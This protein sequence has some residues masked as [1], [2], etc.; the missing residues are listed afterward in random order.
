MALTA[1]PYAA[2]GPGYVL[3]DWFALANA[4]FDGW[5]MAAGADQW[6]ARPGAGAVYAL[7]FGLVG[8]RPGLVFALQSVL[9]VASAWAI[10]RLLARFVA[11]AA[12]WTV[13]AAWIV[14]P[15][16][17]SLL[18]WP[19]AMNI[20]ASLLLLLVGLDLVW[21]DRLGYAALALAASV[22]AYEATAGAALLGVVAVPALAQRGWRRPALV[23]GGAVVAAV[24]WTIAFFHPAKR[25]LDVTADLSLLLPAHAGWGVFPDGAVAMA[26]GLVFSLGLTW[27]AVESLRRRRWSGDA[28]LTF[29]GIAVIVVGTLPF[30]AYFYAPLGAGDRVNVV[31]GVGTAMAWV[32]LGRWAWAHAPGPALA[33]SG[34]V[35]AAMLVAA[36]S[37]ATAWADAVDDGERILAGLPDVSPGGSVDVAPPPVRRNVAAFLDPSNIRSAVQLEARTREV[38]VRFRP[39]R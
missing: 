10:M 3:D 21:R 4:H 19:S 24:A 35:V 20:T 37:A 28:A 22:L 34:L 7:A 13:S 32:G 23:G 8:R 38:E 1:A 39:G 6:R 9:V 25:G 2:R 31:A 15:N 5:W 26:G 12:A 29:A 16:H 33:A 17:G 30:V 18:F 14:V 11:P 36:V 27:M